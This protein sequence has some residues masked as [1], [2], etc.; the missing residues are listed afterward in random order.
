MSGNRVTS[1]PSVAG[2][3]GDGAGTLVGLATC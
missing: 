2:T 1:N 3:V